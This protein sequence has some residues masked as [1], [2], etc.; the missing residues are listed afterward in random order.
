MTV[1]DLIKLIDGQAL[2]G[3]AGLGNVVGSGLS[4]DLLSWVMSHG[5]AGMALITV[6][7]HMNVVAV[8][9]LLDIACLVVTEGIA[10]PPDVVARAAQEGVAVL[11]TPRTAYDVC[12]A[13][14]AA[15]IP[16]AHK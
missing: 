5:V 11:S 10:V 4:C 6:Q 7:T 3:D 8:C 1:S 14:M 15:G 16:P 13:M 9:A 2:T 12:G